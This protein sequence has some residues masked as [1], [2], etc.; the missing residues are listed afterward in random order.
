MI[1]RSKHTRFR[2]YQLKSKG[3]SFSYWDGANFT[4]CEGRYNDD[5]KPSVL[6]ELRT[7]GRSSVDV[8]HITGWDNDHCNPAELAELL[9]QLKPACIEQPGYLP[10]SEPGKESEKLIIKYCTLLKKAR[11]VVNPQNVSYL[12]APITWDYTDILFANPKNNADVNDNSSI[13]LFRSGCFNVLSMGDS[14]SEAICRY[15]LQSPFVLNE[16]DILL[17]SH[18]GSD[19]ALNSDRFLEAIK[20]KAAIALCN[21]SNQHGHPD[22]TVLTRL[23]NRNIPCYSTKLGDVIIESAGDHMRA[24]RTWNYMCDNEKL[25]SASEEHFT[26]KVSKWYEQYT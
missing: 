4:L 24:F 22:K 26:K 3:S 21:W 23:A 20:P 11:I 18:H 25:H 8:L 15:L 14:E 19:N 9:V 7:C 13:R 17:L 5:N 1:L 16:V 10:Q 6:H 12:P 2:A